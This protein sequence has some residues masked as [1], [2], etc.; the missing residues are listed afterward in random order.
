[1]SCFYHRDGDD[2]TDSDLD[3]R[4]QLSASSPD[5]SIW[6]DTTDGTDLRVTFS[7]A[8]YGRYTDEGL[9]HQLGRLGQSMWVAFQRSQKEIHERRS[10]SFRVAVR[11][12][13]RPDQTPAQAAYA[14]ALDEVAAV[15]RSPDGSITVRTTGA[16]RWA[17]DL[18]DGT[19]ARLA[20]GA[21]VGQL[22]AAVQAMLADRERRIAALKAEF[23]DLGVPRRWTDLLDQLRSQNRARD[24]R[25]GR[26]S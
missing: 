2:V 19:V 22:T 1:M 15:G 5:G 7:Y 11:A 16:L 20:E 3:R 8:T 24:Q 18:A 10:A 6:A 12:P 4:P 9:A 17:V 26:G 13:A 14:R 21:F 25:R 23:L